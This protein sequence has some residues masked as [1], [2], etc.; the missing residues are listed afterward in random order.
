M[1]VKCP[2][3]QHENPDDTLYCGKCAEPLKSTEDI[4][5]TKT[6]IT[7]VEVMQKGS[8]IA[9]GTRYWKSWVEE[10]WELSTKQ[11]TPSSKEQ[12]LSSF[13]HQS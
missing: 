12:L 9:E 10:G 2:K 5:M 11:R 7:P 13:S 1:S 6:L 8:P 3:C 4:F